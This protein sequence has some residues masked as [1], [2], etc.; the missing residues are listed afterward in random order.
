ML[1][2][3]NKLKFKFDYTGQVGLPE[4]YP[5]PKI[6]KLLFYIQRNLNVNTIVYTLNLDLNGHICE[7]H[8]MDVFWVNYENGV[9]KKELNKIQDNLAYGYKSWKINHDTYKF[10]IVSYP[11]QDFYI[12]KDERGAYKVFSIL[13]D[14]MSV[15]TNIFVYAEQFGVFPQVK[16]IE[17]FGMT[18]TDNFPIYKKTLL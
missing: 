12:A 18:V 13:N 4:S 7:G 2:N 17:F 9:K 14:Q 1:D 11:Y 6:D 15:V 5:S 3:F 16:F 10:Q 8:P